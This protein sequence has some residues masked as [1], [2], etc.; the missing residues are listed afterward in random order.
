MTREMLKT[1]SDT[2][3]EQVGVW[4]REETRERAVKRKQETIARIRDL[5]AGAGVHIKISGARG[6]PTKA[7]PEPKRPRAK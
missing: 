4:T 5:A 6:R 3:L 7:E 2:E 1:L